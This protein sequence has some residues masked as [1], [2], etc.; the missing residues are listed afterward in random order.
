MSLVNKN[1]L[2]PLAADLRSG[3]RSLDDY[4]EQVCTRLSEIEPQ[5]QAFVPEPNRCER[6][7]TE[8]EALQTRYPTPAD[9]PPLFGVVMGV[10]D[11]FHVAGFPTQ[12]GS[13][14]PAEVLGGPEA[15]YITK[16]KQAGVLILGKT[17]TTEFAYFEP[18][19]TRNPHNLA[20]TPGGSSSGSA[21]AVAAGLCPLASGTQTIGSVVRP[22]A[23]CGIVGFKPSYGRIDPT[24]VIFVSRSLDHVGLFTQDVAGMQLAAPV[25]CADWHKA[26]PS[27]AKPVLGVPE[28]EYLAQASDEALAAFEQHLR[29]LQAAGYEVR[30]VKTMNDIASIAKRHVELMAAEM[31][32]EHAAWFPKYKTL[33]R[34]RTEALI[35]QGM[36]VDQET[37]AAHRKAQAQ[38]RNTLQAQMQETGIDVW[39]TPAAP[40]PAPKGLHATGN[41]AMNLPWTQT[42]LPSI[43]V[44]ASR[45]KNGLP[46]GLQLVSQFMTDEALL[47]WADPIAKVFATN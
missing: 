39:V 11:I 8:A 21:A 35:Q 32:Q 3:K 5:V 36:D 24:G 10:K 9:R 22:A 46:L 41:P 18:G 19:P 15:P 25:V 31:A 4:I 12:A 33:Y 40:G 7:R 37:I 27:A 30:R 38:L 20:H 47:A 13:K 14:F 44:P 16:L 29:K 6:L 1:P 43:T 34:P 2:A 17:V 45:A 42:G 23:F 26:E 28:G